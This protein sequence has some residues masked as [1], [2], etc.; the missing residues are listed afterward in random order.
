MNG[1]RCP[2]TYVVESL[3]HH[4]LVVVEGDAIDAGE[5]PTVGQAGRGVGP[6]KDLG[7]FMASV[8]VD[9]PELLAGPR[10]SPWLAE[11]VSIVPPA[12][13]TGRTE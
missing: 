1:I 6:Q 10:C 11:D 12:A 2:K 9:R 8:Y 3:E 7:S 5:F 13:A 4:S